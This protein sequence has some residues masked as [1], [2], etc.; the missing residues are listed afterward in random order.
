V[1][2]ERG[3]G[4]RWT[5]RLP[6]AEFRDDVELNA[7]ETRLAEFKA[8]AA[9]DAPQ[10]DADAADISSFVWR[11]RKLEIL[12]WDIILQFA[13]KNNVRDLYR[14]L[15]SFKHGAIPFSAFKEELESFKTDTPELRLWL[16]EGARL[17]K[18]DDGIL[19]RIAPE[20]AWSSARFNSYG[21]ATERTVIF[22]IDPLTGRFG[23]TDRKLAE[24]ADFVPY[25]GGSRDVL[26]RGEFFGDVR[27]DGNPIQL[28]VWEIGNQEDG[29]RKAALIRS[30]TRCLLSMTVPERKKL[31]FY[32]ATWRR[33]GLDLDTGRPRTLESV[34]RLGDEELGSLLIAVDDEFGE[35]ITAD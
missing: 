28:G 24:H 10:V 8:V 13:R 5:I 26:L 34:A 31:L 12:L 30:G 35:Y 4:T 17:V 3:R 18:R 25:L 19:D 33:G 2:S 32:E 11:S 21:Q 9:S 7:L 16:A 27:K 1:R 15:L 14:L 20:P 6:R 29:L 23:A 22:T